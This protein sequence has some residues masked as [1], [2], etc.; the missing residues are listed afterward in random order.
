MFNKQCHGSLYN[1]K[2]IILQQ[3]APHMGLHLALLSR[4]T[5]STASEHERVPNVFVHTNSLSKANSPFE[6]ARDFSNTKSV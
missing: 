5:F 3:T 6:Q 4:N 2:K 1:V